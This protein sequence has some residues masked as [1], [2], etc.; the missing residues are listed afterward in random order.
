MLHNLVPFT[1]ET[2]I[3]YLFRTSITHLPA[4][5]DLWKFALDLN[6]DRTVGFSIFGIDATEIFFNCDG[7]Y[8]CTIDAL[9]IFGIGSVIKLDN[10]LAE[11]DQG[12]SVCLRFLKSH[13][14]YLLMLL[15][16]DIACSCDFIKFQMNCLKRFKF[17]K[18]YIFLVHGDIL[19]LLLLRKI[20]WKCI[21]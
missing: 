1:K 6:C 9:I 21:Y 8:L 16:I 3:P 13:L 19:L 5:I 17:C 2:F 14:K 10:N 12:P 4:A 7:K 20:D 11:C 15:L 18:I